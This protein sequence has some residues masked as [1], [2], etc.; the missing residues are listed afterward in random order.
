MYSDGQF[1]NIERPDPGQ[2]FA[3]PY[4]RFYP[5][6]ITLAPNE[7]QAVKVQLTKTNELNSGEYR[8]HLYFRAVPK[9]ESRQEDK[10]N[11]KR[12]E[13]KISLKPIYGISIANIIQI[14][15]PEVQVSISDLDFEMSNHSSPIISMNFNRR[16]KNSSYG[17]IRVRHISNKGKETE[18]S[19]IRGFAVYAPGNL[20]KARIE[21]KNVGELDLSSG[22]LKVTY[23]SQGVG[24]TYAEAT[25]NLKVL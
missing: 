13:L 16:G 18:L 11:D 22:K 12:K 25:M 15:K 10:E 23:T 17:D 7:T 5:R 8:S 19:V 1:E 2:Q 21:L 6:T 9:A 20:R 14:G 3:S 4:L 24:K